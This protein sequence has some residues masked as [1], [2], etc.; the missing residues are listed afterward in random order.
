MALEDGGN[1]GDDRERSAPGQRAPSPGGRPL[2]FRLPQIVVEG[3]LRHGKKADVIT[4]SY[5]IFR[6]VELSFVVTIPSEGHTKAPVYIRAW[7]DRNAE[8]KPGSVVVED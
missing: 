7:I 4:F 5:R 2:G 1:G 8:D 6:I 3:V